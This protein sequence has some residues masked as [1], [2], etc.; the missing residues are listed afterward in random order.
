MKI[1]SRDEWNAKPPKDIQYINKTVNY[2]VIHHTY[3]PV[4]CF[5]HEDCCKAMRSMQTYHQDQN[6]WWDIGYS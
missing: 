6:G 1:I 4:A 5:T 3:R 2:V